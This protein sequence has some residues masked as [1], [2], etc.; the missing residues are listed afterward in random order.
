MHVLWVV[1]SNERIV[2]LLALSWLLEIRITWM[3]DG[4]HVDG[5]SRRDCRGDMY[6]EEADAFGEG[7]PRI[8]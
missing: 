5:G 8:A 6:H 3:V 4:T 1:I 7:T 2:V